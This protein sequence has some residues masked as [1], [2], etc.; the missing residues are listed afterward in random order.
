MP[1]FPTIRHTPKPEVACWQRLIIARYTRPP[2]TSLQ[3]ATRHYLRRNRFSSS[4]PPHQSPSDP[5]S[6]RVHQWPRCCRSD[7]CAGR[8]A[9]CCAVIALTE[10]TLHKPAHAHRRSKS[11]IT[12]QHRVSTGLGLGT[13]LATAVFYLALLNFTVVL[14][15]AAFSN[16]SF[17]VASFRITA[18]ILS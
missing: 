14:C 8:H 10:Q 18:N 1:T 5:V 4:A 17:S 12:A 16:C 2:C 7:H 11:R 6:L 15:S 13:G 9:A 3:R